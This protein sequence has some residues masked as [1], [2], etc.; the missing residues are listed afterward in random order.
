MDQVK[1][2]TLLEAPHVFSVSGNINDNLP[3][4]R[5]AD[6]LA[7]CES[8]IVDD[9]MTQ[10]LDTSTPVPTLPEDLQ[11]DLDCPLLT[12]NYL[13]GRY[14]HMKSHILSVRR[15]ISRNRKTWNRHERQMAFGYYKH[16]ASCLR[17]LRQKLYSAGFAEQLS[18][19]ETLWW[20]N[21]PFI[22]EPKTIEQYGTGLTEDV[23]F[24]HI[25][26]KSETKSGFVVPPVDFYEEAENASN[27]FSSTERMHFL[28]TIFQ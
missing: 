1:D 26:C 12:Q 28:C 20:Y 10:P 24:N 17:T 14:L 2:E 7:R 6:G 5:F 22:V 8:G 3:A 9:V 13:C 19:K 18:F 23:I 11:T 25:D 27:Y 16:Y 21:L 4:E 15:G